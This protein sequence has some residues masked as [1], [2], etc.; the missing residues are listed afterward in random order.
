VYSNGINHAK[1]ESSHYPFKII[2]E[3]C[4]TPEIVEPKISRF[5][6]NSELHKKVKPSMQDGLSN[7]PSFQSFTFDKIPVDCISP[8]KR[9]STS[10]PNTPLKTPKVRK[11]REKKEKFQIQSCGCKGKIF[12]RHSLFY[13]S[14]GVR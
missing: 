10:E 14:P 4:W 11:T 13:Y 6:S 9:R 2:N 3:G 8:L 12:K 5:E 7:L 1:D